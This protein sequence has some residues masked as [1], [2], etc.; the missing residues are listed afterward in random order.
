MRAACLYHPFIVNEADL[1]RVM[2]LYVNYFD[3]RRPHRSP[4]QSAV[5]FGIVPASGQPHRVA[6]AVEVVVEILKT[7]RR[8][9]CERDFRTRAGWGSGEFCP[10]P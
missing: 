6:Y 8:V 10:R 3:H 2:A 9:G 5:R 7:R 4:G 1:R